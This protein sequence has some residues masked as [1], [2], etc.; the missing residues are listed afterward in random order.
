MRK[1]LVL[2]I[3]FASLIANAH[4]LLQEVRYTIGPEFHS[5][6][7]SQFGVGLVSSFDSEAHIPVNFQG[8]LSKYLELGGK[9]LMETTE[10]KEW[11]GNIDVG[12]KIF[13][14]S[15]SFIAIDGYF[16]INRD[17]GGA[18]ALTYGNRHNVAKNFYMDYEA[19]AAYGDA[20]VYPD[21]LFKLAAGV[22][23]TLRFGNPVTASIELNTSGTVDKL[24]HDYKMDLIP[25]LDVNFGAVTIRGE[26][27]IAILLEDNNTR[28]I[29]GLYI[30]YGF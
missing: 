26:Y 11:R 1:L 10:G 6:S 19:R 16:G 4:D 14:S 28:N 2:F 12:G 13:F 27:N 8:Q 23:P 9:V 22:I 18:L 5:R 3:L 24:K 15:G 21:G 20:V 25:R 7:K 29:I 17:N 30:L